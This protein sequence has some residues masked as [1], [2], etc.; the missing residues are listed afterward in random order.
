MFGLKIGGGKPRTAMAVKRELNNAA[1][2]ASVNPTAANEKKVKEL[3][4]EYKAIQ[5]KR[6]TKNKN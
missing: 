6:T 5:N 3:E 4:A 1:Y 2:Q